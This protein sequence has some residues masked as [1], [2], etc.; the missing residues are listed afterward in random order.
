M[1]HPFQMGEL[2]VPP[3][4]EP[5]HINSCGRPNAVADAVRHQDTAMKTLLPTTF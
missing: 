2:G 3:F 5:P 4:M 1:K